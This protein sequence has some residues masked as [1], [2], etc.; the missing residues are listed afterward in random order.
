MEWMAQRESMS[1]FA[2]SNDSDVLISCISKI[3]LQL[4]RK[5]H[6]KCRQKER[7]NIV[8]NVV[9]ICIDDLI[10]LFQSTEVSH[11]NTINLHSRAATL[12]A[13]Q[14]WKKKSWFLI[15]IERNYT[16]RD[17]RPRT[18]STK[19]IFL[20]HDLFDYTHRAN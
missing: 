11:I 18:L 8:K 17:R 19:L 5:W 7:E 20:F 1:C 2:I 13:R 4:Q 12:F 16:R 3:R 14:V 6:M 9:S 15:N 10:L